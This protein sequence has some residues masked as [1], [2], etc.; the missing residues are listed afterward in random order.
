MDLHLDLYASLGK[1]VW[2]TGMHDIRLYE[3]LPM[4]DVYLQ[5]VMHTV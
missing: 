1:V 5:H 2:K 3:R 4:H